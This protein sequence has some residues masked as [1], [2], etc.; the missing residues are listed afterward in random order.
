MGDQFTDDD[1]LFEMGP[2]KKIYKASSTKGRPKLIKEVENDR[3]RKTRASTSQEVDDGDIGRRDSLRSGVLEQYMG[4]ISADITLA[5]S[6]G[7]YEFFHSN[8]LPFWATFAEF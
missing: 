4:R 3:P 2:P 1:S 6:N 7:E 8:F 5:S